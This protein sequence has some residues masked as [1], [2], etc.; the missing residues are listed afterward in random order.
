M[1]FARGQHLLFADAD[2]ASQFSDLKNLESALEL[3]Q[4]EHEGQAS[5]HGLVLGSRAHM[6]D[7]DVVVK[8]SL[9]PLITPEPAHFANRIGQKKTEVLPA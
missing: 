8:V 2:G 5:E 9:V 3:L 1:M 6:V 7:T 4:K